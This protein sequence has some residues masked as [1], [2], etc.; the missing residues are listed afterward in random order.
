M[1]DSVTPDHSI[2]RTERGSVIIHSPNP[3]NAATSI[4]RTVSSDGSV[5]LVYSVARIV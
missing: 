2:V 5:S 3:K 4:C 1:Y